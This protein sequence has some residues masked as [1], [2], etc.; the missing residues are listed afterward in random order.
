MQNETQHRQGAEFNGS[1]AAGSLAAGP[2]LD[3]GSVAQRHRRRKVRVEV[4]VPEALMGEFDL[5]VQEVLAGPRTRLTQLEQEF[6]AIETRALAGLE[7]ILDC[8]RTSG[9]G[10]AA[11][12]VRFLANLYLK[13]DC[14]FDLM[15]LRTLDTRLANACLDY[16]NYDRLGV[17]DLDRHLADGGVEVE[18]W[19]RDYGYGP[20]LSEA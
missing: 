5:M 10:Q 7:V 12:L 11:R 9:A 1:D 13:Y 2:V 15:D 17:C 8:V 3:T 20:H 14:P 18:G 16:L 4:E 6:K 19:I